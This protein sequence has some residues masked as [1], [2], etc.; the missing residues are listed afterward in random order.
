MVLKPFFLVLA[1]TLAGP[2][3]GIGVFILFQAM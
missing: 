3:V 1:A 2:A